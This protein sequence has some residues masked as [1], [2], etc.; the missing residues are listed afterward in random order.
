MFLFIFIFLVILYKKNVVESVFGMEEKEEG[1]EEGLERKE[2]KAKI[3][4]AKGIRQDGEGE[5]ERERQRG[6]E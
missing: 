4:A 3:K 2:L 1:R 5:K 6:S